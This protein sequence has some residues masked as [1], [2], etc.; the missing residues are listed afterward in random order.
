M[1]LSVKLIVT[2]MMVLIIFATGIVVGAQS[3]EGLTLLPAAPQYHPNSTELSIA[4]IYNRASLS[5]VKI[6]VI[7]NDAPGGMGSGFVIDEQ[8]HIVT[9]NHVAGDAAYIEVEFVDGTIAEATLIGHDPGSDLA[10]I[11][12]DPSQVELNPIALADSDE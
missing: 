7:G 6:S 5:V 1:K 9:N 11:K 4:D 2:L 10:V 8:G 3:F 12:V